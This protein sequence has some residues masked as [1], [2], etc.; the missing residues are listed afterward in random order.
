MSILKVNQ[1]K[2]KLRELFEAQLDLSDI[3]AHDSDREPKVLTRC[4]AALAVMLETGC[5]A[6]DAAAAVWDGTDDNGIDAAYYDPSE[7]RVLLVQSKWIAKGSGEP[8]AKEIG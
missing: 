4:L 5:S 1:T 8:E 6:K 2:N 7:S 3:P